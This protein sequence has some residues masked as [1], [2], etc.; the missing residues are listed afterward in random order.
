[1]KNCP[2]CGHPLQDEGK[3]GPIR[4]PRFVSHYRR[5]CS[6]PTEEIS[7]EIAPFTGF[8]AAQART[9]LLD[10]GLPIERAE[11]LIDAW[12]SR[13]NLGDRQYTYTLI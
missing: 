13:G 3:T 8:H 12:N 7:N 10:Q 5:V 4:K 6:S 11:W 2:H 1:M 9:V